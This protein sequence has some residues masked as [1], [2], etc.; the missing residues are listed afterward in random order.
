MDATE[1]DPMSCGLSS[2]AASAL[3]Q[4]YGL[5]RLPT[6]HAPRW[7]QQLLA[8]FYNTLIAILL[9][10]A[11]LSLILGHLVDATV[12]GVVIL[13]NT[14]LGFVQENRAEKAMQAL[15]SFLAPQ[16]LACRDGAWQ[17][18][19]AEALVPGDWVR[20]ENGARISADMR[21]LEAH[22]LR[23]D[24][25]LLT[26][27][28]VPVDKTT[29]GDTGER[30][31]RAG[32]LV[33]GGNGVG[34]VTATGSATEIGRIHQLMG[35]TPTMRSPLL[36]RISRLSRTLAFIVILLAAIAAGIAWWRGETLEF[37]LLAA[38]SLAVAIIPEG[39]PAVIS[40][41][42][43]LGVQRMAQRGTIVRQLP[44]VETLGTVTVI[45]TDKTGTLT[46]NR[47]TVQ[48][49]TL[50]DDSP[51]LLQRAL[52]VMI[53]CNDAQL[54]NDKGGIG[55]PLEQALL[56]YAGTHDADVDTLRMGSPRVDTRPFSHEQPFMATR[57][58]DGIAIKGAPEWVLQR[59]QRMATGSGV[60][61]VDPAYWH[62]VIADMATAGMRTIALASAMD[63][64]WEALDDG[65]WTW[66]GVVALLDPPRAAASAAIAACR[67]AGI[68]VIMVTGD[69]PQTAATVA[70][71]V[72]ILE[73]GPAVVVDH[74]QWASADA[75]E[76]QALARDAVVFARVQPAD[77]LELVQT[78]QASG[79]VVA[80]T[81]DGVND[82]PAL[83]RAQI[84]VAMGQ[85]GSDV[86]REAAAMVLS[87][88]DF[89]HIATAVAEG[90]HIYDNIR[91]TVLYMLPTNFAQGLVIFFAVLSGMVLPIT[92]LQILWVNTI[93]ASTLALVFAFMGADKDVMRRT[94][95]PTREA[96]I[97]G[98]LW[99][100]IAGL[101]TFL[102]V[103]VF[104]VFFGDA[105]LHSDAHA[106][107]LAV[108]T[109]MAM[110]AGIL[111]AMYGRWRG[112]RGDIALTVAILAALIAQGLF[113]WLPFF[114]Q[115]FATAAMSG[116][117]LGIVAF[118]AVL[119][120]LIGGLLGLR[121]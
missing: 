59:C 8:Q 2:A 108:N 76:R 50:A 121:R 56:R 72:G 88:D 67:N 86:A 113:A 112:D 33:T 118:C 12:I 36:E 97:P 75:Q 95:R 103:T 66:L 81:G 31:L 90:R 5:N 73:D 78:L 101:S 83:R 9:A 98:P 25:S 42:L 114:Q 19:P 109:L 14:M 92:P 48:D 39:L 38:I 115:V 6:A 69:H 51:D 55:D 120:W 18:L 119:A 27:E 94:P 16:A 32:T 46:E 100:R 10:A 68:R 20:V 11:L 70:R 7:W 26:G 28:S 29:S 117:D 13:I 80:M 111:L 99:W 47:M 110:E 104:V 82:A 63:G 60:A 96:L 49:L 54:H 1:Q 34:Q 61:E 106:H 37:A 65:G 91:R 45:C 62:K 15:Q 116:A 40:V 84:G 79:E 41:T 71:Q 52:Q 30:L 89:A 21:L 87:D 44:A 35:N 22:A 57:H 58:A 43:A 3:Q 85:S 105:T 24:E 17:H 74:A 107:T 64:Q 93:T 53:L 102:V 77:K 23:V 4:Q